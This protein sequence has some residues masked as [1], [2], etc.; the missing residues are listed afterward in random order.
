MRLNCVWV[1]TH[2]YSH[3]VPVPLLANDR[4]NKTF[5]KDGTI[6]HV[7]WGTGK[8]SLKAQIGVPSYR[9]GRDGGRGSGITK[10]I[11]YYTLKCDLVMTPVMTS[12]KLN[13][14]LHSVLLKVNQCP[15]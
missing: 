5:V 7:V 3:S 10:F 11:S 1:Y 14:V 6:H 13:Q 15:S 12:V 2:A 9:V 4:C 8:A